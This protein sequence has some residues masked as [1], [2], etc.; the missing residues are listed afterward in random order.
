VL[1]LSITKMRAISIEVTMIGVPSCVTCFFGGLGI[2]LTTNHVITIS[3]DN[4]LWR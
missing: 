3:T 2:S 1:D 4:M